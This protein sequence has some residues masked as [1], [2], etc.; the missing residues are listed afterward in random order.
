MFNKLHQSLYGKHDH[1]FLNFFCVNK[2]VQNAP[3]KRK[4]FK[5]FMDLLGQETEDTRN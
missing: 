5:R 1:Y 2:Y 3:K 4:N